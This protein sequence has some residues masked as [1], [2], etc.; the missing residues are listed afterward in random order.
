M[1]RKITRRS[2]IKSSAGATLGALAWGTHVSAQDTPLVEPARVQRHR[3]LTIAHLTDIHVKPEGK[4]PDGMRACLRHVHQMQPPPDLIF[5]GGDAIMSVL[6]ASEARAGEQFTLW[7]KIL[8]AECHLP[9]FHCIGNHDCWG[10]Q[11][12]KAGT[13]GKELKY[14]KTWVMEIHEMEKPYYRFDRAGWRFIVLDSV[15]ERGDGGYLP[16]LDEVQFDWLKSE[17]DATAP[18]TPVL[19]LSHVP[20]ISVGPFFF[21]DDIV[22]NY[23]FRLAG[24]LMHQDTHRLKGLLEQYSNVRLCLS[25]HVHLLDRVEY[26]GITY[27]SNGSVSG[28]WWHGDYKQT[29]PGYGLVHL[30]DDGSFEADY[31]QYPWDSTG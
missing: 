18:E 14:G 21:Y 10:W 20:I 15:Q 28:S 27:I 12:S 4:G 2:W 22:E 29:P 26:N 24:A 17:L 3:V 9:I 19:L 30:F 23:Q 8:S 11:R 5:N 6:G 31:I 7:K 13:T 1:A 25:G 16:M